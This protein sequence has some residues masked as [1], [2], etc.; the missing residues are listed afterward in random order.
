MYVAWVVTVLPFAVI[1]FIVYSAL[2]AKVCPE[3]LMVKVTEVPLV[4]A[5]EETGCGFNNC[6]A[7][8]ES[9]YAEVIV[10]VDEPVF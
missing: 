4:I 9:M 10:T 3:T 2:V 7:A 8:F 1:S 6:V 5:T